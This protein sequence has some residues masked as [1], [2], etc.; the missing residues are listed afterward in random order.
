MQYHNFVFA[1]YGC[2][3]W[4]LTLKVNF[5]L[6]VFENRVLKETYWDL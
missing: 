1:V 3:N 4:S 6:R 2:E 5:K